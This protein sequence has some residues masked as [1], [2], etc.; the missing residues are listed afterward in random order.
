MGYPVEPARS[1]RSPLQV[2]A[3]RRHLGPL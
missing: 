1:G 3:H 2:C